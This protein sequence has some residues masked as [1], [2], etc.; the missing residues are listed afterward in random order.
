VV[1]G[2]PEP[3]SAEVQTRLLQ[4]RASLFDPDTGLPTLPLVL[5]EVGRM[6]D[7][8]PVHV[9]LIRIEQEQNLESMLGWERYD[10]LLR[11]LAATLADLLTTSHG[12]A[13][14]LCQLWVRGDEFVV[15]TADRR[16]RSRLRDLLQDL[17]LSDEGG[18][19]GATVPLRIGEGRVTRRAVQRL[20]R[21]IYQGVAE[22][23]ADFARRGQ[24][25]DEG[26]Q[27]ELRGILRERRVR[28]L[29][30]PIYRVPQRTVI[31]YEALSRG[32]EG[33]YLESAD[34]LFGFSDRAGLLGELERLCVDRAL[35][36]APACPS[37]RRSSSTCRSA[38]SSS[39][40]RRPAGSPTWCGRPAGRRARSCSS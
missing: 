18:G 11:S 5:D 9:I 32:P 8:G 31:G 7:K 4:Y 35:S 29:F 37:A 33:S 16:E 24:S 25:L 1:D 3:G 12:T 6:L 10:R 14:V 2:A 17:L 30:Q 22:A 28:T 40:S 19:E 20:E 39:W 13:S 23:R 26:R 15:F 38:G 21:C 36:N 34:K 27:V